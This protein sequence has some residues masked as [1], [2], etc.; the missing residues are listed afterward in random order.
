MNCPVGAMNCRMPRRFRGMRRAAAVKNNS[1]EIVASP[2]NK[3]R[4]MLEGDL[5]IQICWFVRCWWQR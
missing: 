2:L 3:M 4:Q 5:S 1:G